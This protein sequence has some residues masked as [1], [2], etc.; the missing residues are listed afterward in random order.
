RPAAGSSAR[1]AAPHRRRH[2]RTDPPP[3]RCRGVPPPR[4]S[5]CTSSTPRPAEHPPR[6]GLLTLRFRCLDRRL[7]GVAPVRPAQV[8]VAGREPQPLHHEGIDRGTAPTLT[9]SD[10][11]LARL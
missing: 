11:R 3:S 8:V 1:A 10:H 2:A 9:V 7:L 6:S 4:R 5:P